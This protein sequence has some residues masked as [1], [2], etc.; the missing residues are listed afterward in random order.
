M[1]GAFT[2]RVFS[3]DLPDEAKHTPG[4]G[5]DCTGKCCWD[6]A[7]HGKCRIECYASAQRPEDEELESAAIS[8]QEGGGESNDCREIAAEPAAEALSAYGTPKRIYPPDS[9]IA[10]R[11]VVR[12]AMTV[13]SCAMDCQIRGEGAILPG[14]ADGESVPM[15]DCK[16]R[17]CRAAGNM[18][19]RKP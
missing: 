18:P 3:C 10:D 8:Q 7:K 5:I 4:D 14:G 2:A 12:E 15:R 17:F 16:R 6:C 9:L 11:R 19:V 1:D 13:S